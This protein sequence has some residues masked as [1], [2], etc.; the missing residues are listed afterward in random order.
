LRAVK[1]PEVGR[2]GLDVPIETKLHAPGPREEWAERA[3][4]I[5]DLIGATAKLILVDAPAGFGK[6][7]LVAQWR[8]SAMESRPFAWISL[9]QGDNDPARLWW[10]ITHAL[11]RACP[12]LGGE[13]ALPERPVQVRDIAGTLLPNL[14][15][16]L[17]ALSAPVVLVLDDYQVVTEPTCHEQIAFLLLHCPSSVQVVLITRTDP[18]LPLA[19]LRAAGDLA[20]IRVPQLRFGPAEAA[21]LVRAISGADLSE[22]D[23]A[24]LVERT[25]GWP[26]GLYLAALS[27]RGHPAPSAFARQFTGDNRFIADFLAE[28]V[29]GRQP[30]EIRQFL[31]RTAILGRFCAPLCDAVAGSANAAEIIGLLERENLFIVPL[32]EVR[33][34]FRYHSLF[35]QVLRGYLARTDPGVVP[36]LHER[37]SA[38]HRKSGSVDEA[39]E[40]ALGAGD[41]TGGIG[42]IA[43]HWY[44]YVDSGRIATVRGWMGLL[45]DSV[46]SAEPVAA[47]CAAWIAALAGDQESV[48]R[49]L[50]VMAAARSEEPLPDG[51][52]S[53]RSSAALLRGVFGFEGYR[54]MRESAAI[55]VELETDPASPW[56]ALARTALGFSRY[57]SGEPEAAEG[58]LE[59]AVSSAAEISLVRM[60]SLSVLALAAVGRGKLA[61]AE[62]LAQAAL[63]LGARGGASETP[64]ASLA[65]VAAGAAYAAQGQLQQA[66]L[67]FEQAIQFRRRVPGTSPWPTV[68]ALVM[69]AQVLADM[70][71]RSGAEAVIDEARLVLVS[72]PE[73]PE[74]LLARLGRLEQQATGRRPTSLADPLTERE[75]AVLSLLQGTLSLREIGQ[76]LHL[77]A[78]TIKTHT[79]A[80][81]RKL[82]VS[83]RRAAVEKGREA[84]LL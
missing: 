70:G 11:R 53:L 50:A 62:E 42:L 69:L 45:G 29:L 27:L 2:A 3:G 64:P 19:G 7:T 46:I 37:A 8:A 20:E 40:H 84:G 83:T 4:L 10:Y 47:H 16:E 79:Q 52:R 15:N 14:V 57:L 73:P 38:W 18:P 17:V 34:W 56:Y 51:M 61:R 66:R 26:V 55:A 81:Y 49:W 54:V 39:I 21:Q 35:A 24:I 9:D 58:P 44:T 30:D 75:L 76:E 28:E 13:T 71:D 68:E 23:L 67:E 1:A 41:F 5:E 43:G 59:E 72:V 22:P 74:A 6:T 12:E 65:Y 32:D 80:V 63:S 25:E 31:A 78:N 60:L 77:S 36:V 48:R 33:Q 82:G